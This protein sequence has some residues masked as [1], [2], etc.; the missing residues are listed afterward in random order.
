MNVR[1]STCY[2]SVQFRGDDLR[3]YAGKF[4]YTDAPK[5]VLASSYGGAVDIEIDGLTHDD[6]RAMKAILDAALARAAEKP[7]HILEAAE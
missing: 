2:G 6:V 5:L 1:K 4:S 3:V 7:A